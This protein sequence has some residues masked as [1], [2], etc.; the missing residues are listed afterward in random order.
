[1]K[2]FVLK[3]FGKPE[4]AFELQEL[5]TPE[6]KPHEV[7]IN[8]ECF[9]LNFADIMARN[10]LYQDCPPLPAVIGYE[11]VGRIEKTGKDVTHLKPGQRVVSLTRFGGYATHAVADARAAVVVDENID[12]GKA[13]ALATQYCTAYFAAEEMVR[14]HEG[15]HVLIDAAAGGVGTALTQMAKHHGCII[16]GGAG[17]DEKLEYLKQQGVQHPINYRKHDFYE[18]AR[19]LMGGNRADVIF[20]SVGGSTVPKS[21]KLLATGGRLVCYG[22][23]EGAG[24]SKFF[25]NTLKLGIDFGLLFP[26]LLV[27]NTKSFIG[28]NMLKVADNKPDTLQ[29]CL[30]GVAKLYEQKIIDP[31]VGGVFTSNQLTEAHHFLESRK[32]IGKIVVKW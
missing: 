28:I 20:N 16:Y 21:M 18:T 27:M 29:R 23:A 13:A 24:R 25:L 19:Q 11:V 30:Q 15:D 32:S 5:P 17:S 7:L 2:A 4:S 26:P 1:M 14:L 10:G 6:P 22:A 12:A 3:K 31:T 8:N 9:G